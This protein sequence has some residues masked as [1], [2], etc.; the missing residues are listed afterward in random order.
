MFLS[1]TVH[2]MWIAP[3][4]NPSFFCRQRVSTGEHSIKRNL[5]F[6]LNYYVQELRVLEFASRVRVILGYIYPYLWYI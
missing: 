1:E 4:E 5:H 3:I 6:Y 2:Y